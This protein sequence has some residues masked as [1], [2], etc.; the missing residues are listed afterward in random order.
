MRVTVAAEI[1]DF[2][3]SCF[4]RARRQPD[5]AG[6]ALHL[7]GVRPLRIREWIEGATE[8]DDVAVAVFPI[9]KEGEAVH[10]VVNAGHRCP[11]PVRASVPH[12]G[13]S[14][15]NCRRWS[16]TKGR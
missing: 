7:V 13:P 6:A 2:A 8:F 16:R 11:K 14:G 1:E 15:G 3:I 12:I 10:D 4:L 9:V 5:L